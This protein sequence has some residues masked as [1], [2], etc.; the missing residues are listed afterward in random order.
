MDG[1]TGATGATGT[2]GTNGA[3]GVTGATGPAS[4]VA[5]PTGAIGATGAASMVPGPTGATGAGGSQGIS[6]P[7][8]ATGSEGA[9]DLLTID[10]SARF[11]GLG[12]FTLTGA[13][14]SPSG[15]AG[16]EVF[17]EVD[18]QQTDLGSATL[19]PGG[20]FTFVDAV[21]THAQSGI[22]AVATD[23]AGHQV[24]QA[25]TFALTA[26][27]AGE[28]YRAEEDGFDATTGAPLGST[29]Y[30]GNGREYFGSTT[31]PEPGGITSYAYSGGVY[32]NGKAFSS[33]TDSYASDGTLVE[34]V[35]DNRDGS[36]AISVE[37]PGQSVGSIGTDTFQA[38]GQAN[39]AFVFT[40]GFGQ[41]AINGFMASGPGHDTLELAASDFSS[42]ADVLRHTQ[43]T[44]GGAVIH[45]PTSGDT[46]Q[47]S[48]VAK[49]DLSAHRQ[50]FRLGA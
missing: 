14:Y 31:S 43:N 15:V 6:G 22:T 42:I 44:A 11:D 18:G 7:T 39:T 3:T 29:F 50:D 28:A 26:G 33:F 21:G 40:P 34:H 10:P 47:L 1:A 38:T 30:L 36:H 46:V 25:A 24:G 16:V 48:G 9:S 2:A 27:I 19:Q 12:R 32:F 37:A 45:D 35:E 8:G 49:A 13:A 17:A 5:G 20:S 23:A 4:T 41:D